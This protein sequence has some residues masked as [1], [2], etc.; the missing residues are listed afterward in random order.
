[1]KTLFL[2]G[3]FKKSY[4][5]NEGNFR[6]VETEFINHMVIVSCIVTRLGLWLRV[7]SVEST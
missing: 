3:R 4:H 1:V 7:S 5:S 2:S 6:F